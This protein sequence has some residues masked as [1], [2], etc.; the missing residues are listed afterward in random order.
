[1]K[2]G[3]SSFG[4]HLRVRS[5][6]PPVTVDPRF[7]AGRLAHATCIDC[8]RFVA[9][10][11]ADDGLE[12]FG[13]LSGEVEQLGRTLPGIAPNYHVH[14]APLPRRTAVRGRAARGRG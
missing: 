3:R 10:P 12:L 5:S 2:R 13:P 14:H 6:M 7:D 11:A 8:F 1:M 9:L 4:V